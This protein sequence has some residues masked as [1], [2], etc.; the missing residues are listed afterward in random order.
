[1]EKML[2]FMLTFLVLFTGACNSIRADGLSQEEVKVRADIASWPQK[3]KSKE[4]NLYDFSVSVLK[5]IGNIPQIWK[6]DAYFDQ[7][8]DAVL[9]SSFEDCSS[10]PLEYWERRPIYMDTKDP[11]LSL[12]G[13]HNTIVF[14]GEL[15]YREQSRLFVPIKRRIALVVRFIDKMEKERRRLNAIEVGEVGGRLADVLERDVWEYLQGQP[16]EEKRLVMAQFEKGIG[17]SVREP[18]KISEER[19]KFNKMRSET[20][21][22]RIRE[23]MRTVYDRKP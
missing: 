13:R 11:M 19:R 1:M 12:Q 17:H 5:D 18:S 22:R 4:N 23:Y 14:I 7:F 15:L 20:I 21:D 8:V 9:A 3:W 2:Y 10:F 16:V 6:R